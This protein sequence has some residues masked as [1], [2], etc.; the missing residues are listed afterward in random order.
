MYF[1]ADILKLLET[2]ILALVTIHINFRT[3]LNGTY[4]G[5]NYSWGSAGTAEVGYNKSNK[6]D[7][8]IKRQQYVE[9][10]YNCDDTSI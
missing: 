5:G 1:W 4:D 3:F 10:Y 6:N 7:N 9:T 8:M 2:R